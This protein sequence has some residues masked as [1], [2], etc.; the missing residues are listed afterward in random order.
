MQTKIAIIRPDGTP[1]VKG[2]Y[3]SQEIG[4][5]RGLSRLGIDVDVYVAGADTNVC[6]T[7]IETTGAGKVRLFETPFFKV[8]EID[9]AI[10]PK[11]I[12]LLEQGQYDLIQVNEEAE[13]NNLRV[14]RFAK[15]AGIPLI[16]Y[17]GMYKPISGRI[18]AAFQ[19]LFDF[20][21]LPYLRKNIKL[22]VT[23]TSR[24]EAYLR[25]KGFKNTIVLP[26]GLD[27]QPFENPGPQRNWR[28]ELAIPAEHSII[29]Y[30]GIF[31]NRRNIHFILDI[32]K[33]LSDGKYTFV[34]AGDGPIFGEIQA[35]VRDENIENV[36]LIGKVKQT[37]LPGLYSDAS[38]FLLAS[39][40]EIYGMVVLEAMYFGTPVCSTKTAGP[41]DIIETGVDGLLFDELNPKVWSLEIDR[42]ASNSIALNEMSLKAKNKVGANLTWNAVA[43]QYK[44]EVVDQLV[45][46]S[47]KVKA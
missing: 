45:D 23:K 11:L 1:I 39:N 25:T 4:L 24:A 19:K 17:Q 3:N 28:E 42:V 46:E 7:D 36:K 21:L 12:P 29:L 27:V 9:H 6:T 33:H 15:R 44:E 8:P 31:E 2:F 40:Y 22:G 20:F 32:A 34:L 5:A 14:A 26:V 43:V 30:V 47:R 16:V 18:R 37:E 35:R 10:Y 38:L 41:E 13:L